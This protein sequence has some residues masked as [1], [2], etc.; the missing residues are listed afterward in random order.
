MSS[1]RTVV[2][3][4]DDAGINVL[5]LR[6]HTIQHLREAIGKSVV[7]T[8][9]IYSFEAVESLDR[10]DREAKILLSKQNPSI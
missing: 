5:L 6:Y 1:H 4:A 10:D 2:L 8:L 9:S 3:F 7:Y